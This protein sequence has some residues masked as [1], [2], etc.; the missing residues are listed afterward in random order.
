MLYIYIYIHL[1]SYITYPIRKRKPSR[2]KGS[3]LHNLPW[4]RRGAVAVKLYSFFNLG[5]RLWW[6]VNA[7]LRPLYPRE[8]PGTHFIGGWVGPRSGPEGSGNLAPIG[9]QSPDCPASSE[10]LCLLCYPCPQT[11]SYTKN[12]HTLFYYFLVHFHPLGSVSVS[13]R[14]GVQITN[15][16]QKHYPSVHNMYTDNYY[17]CQNQ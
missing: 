7:T 15:C 2:L 16:W 9:I 1:L 17:K 6:L 3:L 12:N 8:W 13:H 5:A 14:K 11:S 10:S 4:R